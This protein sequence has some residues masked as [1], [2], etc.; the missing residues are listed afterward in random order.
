MFL[1][2]KSEQEK[3]YQNEEEGEEGAKKISTVINFDNMYR[4]AIIS[5]AVIAL[6]PLLS[7]QIQLEETKALLLLP[8][9]Q[10]NIRRV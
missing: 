10:G 6:G 2:T 9:V 7:L 3:N 1:V 5:P 8:R 4:I